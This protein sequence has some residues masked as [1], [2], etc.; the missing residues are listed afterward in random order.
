MN[1]KKNKAK[2]KGFTLVELLV[3]V[4]IIAVI[5]LSLVALYSSGQ[6]YFITESARTD[7]LQDSRFVLNWISRDIKEA[8]QVIPSWG[9]YTTATDCLV[10][11]I[12]S[13]DAN[14][15][16]ID[17]ANDF[18][19]IVYRLNPDHPQWLERIV[20]A[21]DGVSFKA[22]STRLIAKN[23]DSFTLSSEGVALSSV[24]DFSAVSNINISMTTRQTIFSK[25]YQETL[26][27][28]VKMRNKGS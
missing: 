9:S 18:D 23:V 14:G 7:M 3:V 24:G 28:E 16:I 27:T 21:K 4:A 25:T 11:E 2:T 22:D 1:V 26:K 10:L 15:L 19:Y 12:P 6:R 17:I 5:V 8:I 20:D 13:I